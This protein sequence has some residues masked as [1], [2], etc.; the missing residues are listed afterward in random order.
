MSTRDLN[1]GTKLWNSGFFYLSLSLP[2]C[3]QFCALAAI[4]KGGSEL[5][6]LQVVSAQAGGR[7]PC[8]A[9]PR[10][11]LLLDIK[12][13]HWLD[14]R[15]QPIT[16]GL[17]TGVVLNGFKRGKV[18]PMQSGHQLWCCRVH[19]IRQPQNIV[20][21]S[22]AWSNGLLF[23][24]VLAELSV[25]CLVCLSRYI[26]GCGLMSHPVSCFVLCKW[27][28]L[29]HNSLGRLVS[30]TVF[31]PD[32]PAGVCQAAELHIA[33]LDGPVACKMLCMTLCILTLQHTQHFSTHN[34]LVLRRYR[35]WGKKA[36]IVSGCLLQPHTRTVWKCVQLRNRSHKEWGGAAS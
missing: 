34:R 5:L 36:V 13:C 9:T 28:P 18:L 35:F 20:F 22:L 30:A 4:L 15:T 25:A 1:L 11:P 24:W 21:H 31:L 8:P 27:N 12:W 33:P 10:Q 19:L 6:V 7:L 3:E 23:S 2:L 29:V 17:W 32:L 26:V 16:L 14:P